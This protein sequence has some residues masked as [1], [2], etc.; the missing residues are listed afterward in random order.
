M[1]DYLDKAVIRKLETRGVT[2]KARVARVVLNP[3]RSVAN[4]LR[5]KRPSHRDTR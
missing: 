2:A 4:V 5:F 1:E 3:G